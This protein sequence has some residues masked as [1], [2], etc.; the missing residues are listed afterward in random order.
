M[1]ATTDPE[2]MATDER[3]RPAEA[4]SC[5]QNRHVPRRS[6]SRRSPGGLMPRR[7][8]GSV[9]LHDPAVRVGL[10]NLCEGAT[11]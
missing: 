7:N 8:R 1:I 2:T 11:E 10:G 6:N 3:R 9:W 4:G 5:G